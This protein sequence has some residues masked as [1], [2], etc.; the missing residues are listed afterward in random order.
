M[1][2]HRIHISCHSNTLLAKQ[3]KYQSITYKSE[4]SFKRP[5]R[6]KLSSV[7]TSTEMSSQSGVWILCSCCFYFFNADQ[8]CCT[9]TSGDRKC[10]KRVRNTC[11]HLPRPLHTCTDDFSGS[12]HQGACSSARRKRVLL[13]KHVD[14]QKT[15]VCDSTPPPSGVEDDVSQWLTW[16]FKQLNNVLWF[17]ESTVK[18]L[19]YR[20]ATGLSLRLSCIMFVLMFL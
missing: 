3:M 10:L 6:W 20:C 8:S 7:N 1:E 5:R 18:M 11:H 12:G 17:F 15:G 4:V 16:G 19:N 13:Q 2:A 9:K 14:V